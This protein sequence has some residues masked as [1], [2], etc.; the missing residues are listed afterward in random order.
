M[1]N[2][3]IC[4]S[5]QQTPANWQKAKPHLIKSEVPKEPFRNSGSTRTFFKSRYSTKLENFK[6][7]DE[8]LCGYDLPELNPDEINDLNKTVRSSEIDVAIILVIMII[9]MINNNITKQSSVQ[10]LTDSLVEAT[11]WSMKRCQQPL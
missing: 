4:K 8:L 3:K 5:D 2:Y 7:L 10:A 11:R 1:K 6:V 9:I